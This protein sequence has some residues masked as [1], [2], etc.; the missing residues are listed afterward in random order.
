MQSYVVSIDMYCI[1]HL[2]WNDASK[3]DKKNCKRKQADLQEISVN[4][5]TV[6][7]S[8]AVNSL[9]WQVVTQAF[10]TQACSATLSLGHST[11]QGMQNIIHPRVTK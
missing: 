5:K 2:S 7:R 3:Q 11:I 1:L 9:T 6:F 4:S 10:S 8:E